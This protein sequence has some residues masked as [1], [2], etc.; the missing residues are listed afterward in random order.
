MNKKTK[1]KIASKVRSVM[2]YPWAVALIPV[3]L[4]MGVGGLIQHAVRAILP[5][6]D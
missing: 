3:G 4:A 6:K 2:R 5:R 1:R